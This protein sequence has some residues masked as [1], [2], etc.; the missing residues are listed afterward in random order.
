MK[1]GLH[2]FAA[3]T[4]CATFCLIIAGAL[5]T[6]REAGLSVPDWPLSYGSLTPPW[7]GNIR[8]EHSHRMIA[9]SVGLL[10]IGLA[11]WLSRR[12]SRLWVRRVGYL[13][14]GAVVMQGLLGG[15]TVLFF[16]PTP[17]SVA[18]ACL[19]QIFF[20]LTV[21]LALVTGERWQKPAGVLE[22]D[23][24]PPLAH[25]TIATAAATFLQLVMGAALRHKG[26][27]IIPHLIGAA[28]VTALVM[29]TIYRVFSRHADLRVITRP[30]GVLGILL[31]AQLLLGAASYLVREATREAPQPL[32]VMVYITV[33]HVA[34]GAATLASTVWL[35][36]ESNRLLR[37]ALRRSAEQAALT[38]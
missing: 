33:A 9:A 18:H 34:M 2:R 17:I 36:L 4:A 16:L 23:G 26:F 22:D 38:T 14:L 29:W 20:C 19:A 28:V 13:A 7:V 12:E 3:F 6:S 25:L 24:A 31:V 35:M 8:Y 21:T 32:A 15:I 37:P 30:A 10:T 11:L 5:V 27:G 1:R